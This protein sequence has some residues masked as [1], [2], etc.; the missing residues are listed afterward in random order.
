MSTGNN[1]AERWPW[2]ITIFLV[3]I[4]IAGLASESKTVQSVAKVLPVTG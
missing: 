1:K 2:G 3:L 4:G